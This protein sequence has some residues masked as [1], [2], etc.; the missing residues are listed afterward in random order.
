M[1][2]LLTGGLGFIGSH[3]A[4]VL[5]QSD[6]EII[7]IDNLSNS[8][9]QVLSKINHLVKEPS[10]IHFIEGDVLDAP[11]MKRVFGSFGK[12]DAVI[13]FASLKSVNESIQYPLMYYR[14]NIDGLITLLETMQTHK[15]MKII[16]SSSS[17]VYGCNAM[18]PI[19][20]T[21][22][23][24]ISITNPYG[25]TKYFQEQILMD[26]E[27]AH[28]E[29]CITILRYFNPAGAHP[30]G[31]LGEDPSGVPNNL[32][33]YILR[34]ATRELAYLTIYGDDYDTQDGTCIR[35]YIHVMDLA[36]GHIA[37]LDHIQPGVEIY[38]LG[39]GTGTSVL[40]FVKT[41]AK[42]NKVEVPY[43]IGL[44]RAGDVPVVYADVTK[45]QNA[46][47]W[48]TKR[49]VEDICRDGYHFQNR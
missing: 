49:T 4:V 35:D 22:P 3:C 19:K 24:G 23:I 40:E 25:Q 46:F 37:A 33:P 48:K 16:F 7:I 14:K 11:F 43:R 29:M 9:I 32:F 41:F 20:E 36:E 18:A 31:L 1:R 17:T 13:H 21:D 12:I 5:G 27:K 10:N 26:Y 2:V 28:P 6:H 44:R 8:S 45:V 30:S 47:G 42:I 38:N 15:C 34:V 39:T